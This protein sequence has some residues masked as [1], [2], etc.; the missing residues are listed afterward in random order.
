MSDE[1][2]KF[3][4]DNSKY[5]V[6]KIKAMLKENFGNE[7][8]LNT[9]RLLLKD[10]GYEITR[11]HDTRSYAVTITEEMK[12][13][14]IEKRQDNGYIELTKMFNERFNKND[15]KEFQTLYKKQTNKF[16]T[17]AFGII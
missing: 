15:F 8:S 9:I 12:Q 11:K 14:I 4:L 10:N 7:R 5:D 13:F 3:V 6:Y 1:E 2:K 17:P 16:P